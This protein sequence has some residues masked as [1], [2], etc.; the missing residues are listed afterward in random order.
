MF[1]K[2]LHFRAIWLTRIHNNWQSYHHADKHWFWFN[3][4]KVRSCRHL[5]TNISSK[6]ELVTTRLHM[7]E[8]ILIDCF[9]SFDLRMM[10]YLFNLFVKALH[11]MLIMKLDFSYILYYL[12]DFLIILSAKK[13]T[14]YKTEFN[15]LCEELEWRVN[16]EKNHE[17]TITEVLDIELDSALI[18]VRLPQNKL[19]KVK[20]LMKE[21]LSKDLMT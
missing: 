5:L 17:G 19:N 1:S 8:L 10:S 11:W 15:K 18:K 4:N 7:G 16:K 21:A 14:Q 20:I 2:W 12:N 9:L 6:T 3:Y 13:I